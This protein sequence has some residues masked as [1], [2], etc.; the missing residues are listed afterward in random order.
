[1]IGR[2]SFGRRG[3]VRLAANRSKRLIGQL[4]VRRSKQ[5][6]SE[7][8]CRSGSRRRKCGGDLGRVR[9]ADD[10]MVVNSILG[11]LAFRARRRPTRF[12]S[13]TREIYSRRRRG[14]SQRLMC[15]FDP[16]KSSVLLSD[17]APDHFTLAL[18]IVLSTTM[19]L[20]YRP[21]DDR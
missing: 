10:P 14:S 3:L 9:G 5:I 7:K 8:R 17:A 15:C 6:E 19:G 18:K 16:L 12:P 4:S 21:I 11:R 2:L 1:M 20:N 13:R